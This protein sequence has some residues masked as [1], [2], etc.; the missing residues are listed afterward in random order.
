MRL[1]PKNQS[2][3]TLIEVTIILLVLVI[4]SMIML[5][6]MG[7][8]NRLARFVKAKEDLI[9]VCATAKKML[10]EVML[11]TFYRD[12]NGDDH[13]VAPDKP[14]G[15]LVGP[16]ALPAEGS[17]GQGDNYVA[18]GDAW[19]TDP[20]DVPSSYCLEVITDRGSIQVRFACDYLANHLQRN[21]PFGTSSG[22]TRY[23]NVFDNL[24]QSDHHPSLH[25]TMVGGIFG[26][27]G[28]YLD[29]L[30][31]DPWG[32]RYMVNSFAL[33][34]PPEG[35]AA[36]IFS[37]AV[38]CYSTGPDLGIDTEFNQPQ[39]NDDE[40]GWETGGDDLAVILSAFGPF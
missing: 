31:P 16:G 3:F 24:D 30:S 37:S 6:Q 36:D 35:D 22:G 38:V 27:R 13:E 40:A 33:F 29:A 12:P 4:L 26:W 10:D 11:S 18:V 7:N 17:V 15:L 8:F 32:N 2:G 14:I 5:P 25:N 9:A 21:N 23:K 39:D 34:A 19:R 1:K 28:P 20:T